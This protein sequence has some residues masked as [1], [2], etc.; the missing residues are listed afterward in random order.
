MNSVAIAIYLYIGLSM[1]KLILKNLKKN[2]R[3]IASSN[4]FA[5]HIRAPH[6][7]AG[8]YRNRPYMGMLEQGSNIICPL[9]HLAPCNITVA[10]G[11]S[12][13]LPSVAQPNKVCC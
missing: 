13:G 7:L 12:K 4:M 8:I 3:G 2:L 5:K 1:V 11:R 9:L 6:P 10:Q